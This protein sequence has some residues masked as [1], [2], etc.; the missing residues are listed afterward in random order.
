[1]FLQVTGFAKNRLPPHP[2]DKIIGQVTARFGKRHDPPAQGLELAYAQL[3]AK[4]FSGDLTAVFA[5]FA[6]GL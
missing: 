3:P 2:P 1:M 4:R 5:G 6:C